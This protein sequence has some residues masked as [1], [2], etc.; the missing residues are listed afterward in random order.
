MFYIFHGE[1]EFTLSEQVGQLRHRV[2]E[3]GLGDLNI[4]VLDGTKVGFDELRA[5]CDTMPFLGDRRLVIVEGLLSRLETQEGASGRGKRPRR[6]RAREAS[7][8]EAAETDASA[9]A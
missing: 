3:A 5:A 8:A 6:R 9:S 2:A 4:T 1:E 7:G